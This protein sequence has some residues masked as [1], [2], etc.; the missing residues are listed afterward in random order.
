MKKFHIL[1]VVLLGFFL[2]PNSTLACGNSSEKKSCKKEISS[3]KTIKKSCCKTDDSKDKGDKGCKGNCGHSKCS[4]SSTCP[5]T[6]LNLFCEITFK[7]NIFNYS[8][9]EKVKFSYQSSS[10]SDGFYSIW[11]LPKIS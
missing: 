10:I 11:L 5:T 8:I 3:S 9:V 6:L 2:M 4:C 1:L 7:K